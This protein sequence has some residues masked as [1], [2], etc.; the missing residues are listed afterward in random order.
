MCARLIYLAIISKHS[1]SH[2]NTFTYNKQLKISY[3]WILAHSYVYSL[4]YSF[5]VFYEDSS[6]IAFAI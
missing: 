4:K 3:S 1:V 2:N 6:K 5:F